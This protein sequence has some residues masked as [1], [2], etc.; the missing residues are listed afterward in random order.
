MLNVLLRFSFHFF[1]SRF[2]TRFSRSGEVSF[3]LSKARY[4]VCS[5][6][7]GASK[8]LAALGKINI[9]ETWDFVLLFIPRWLWWQFLHR[10][11]RF[12]SPRL[13]FI[14][15]NQTLQRFDQYFLKIHFS[16]E[17]IESFTWD[18]RWFYH[19]V[20]LGSRTPNLYNSYNR[21]TWEIVSVVLL[22]MND[23]ERSE[24]LQRG[25]AATR[26]RASSF[27]LRILYVGLNDPILPIS[28]LPKSR[29]SRNDVSLRDA[30]ESWERRN[31]GFHLRR[32]NEVFRP[33]RKTDIPNI[34]ATFSCC[35]L[36]RRATMG[37]ASKSPG[38]QVYLRSLKSSDVA[39]A[40]TKNLWSP[41]WLS[42]V[43]WL[44]T[45]L[46]FSRTKAE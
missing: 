41:C 37:G 6:H 40:S 7:I 27:T 2:L 15:H 30:L 3:V 1:A 22:K 19:R 16:N 5:S 9:E 38:N 29:S 45:W 23:K 32:L 26:R 10:S 44:M 18:L 12:I 28:S 46:S 21:F 35:R 4:F 25:D 8:I 31:E 36:A 42:E 20:V 34:T 14:F 17:C 33:F 13:F 24:L 11:F 39:K 43:V